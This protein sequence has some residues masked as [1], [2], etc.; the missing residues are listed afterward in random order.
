[1]STDLPVRDVVVCAGGTRYP[2][3]VDLP[4]HDPVVIAADSGLH[5]A[6]QLSLPV[7]HVVGDFDSV[8]PEALNQA[9]RDGA[10]VERH[11]VDK[12]HTDLALA[13]HLAMTWQPARVVVIGGDGG[14]FD[15]LMGVVTLLAAP[16]YRD[17]AIIG[18]LGAN[19][20]TV[21]HHD[22]ELYGENGDVV[23]LV[24]MHGPAY[25]VRTHGLRFALHGE[26]LPAGS[27]R[28]VSNE[29]ARSRAHVSLTRGVLLA[30]QPGE[31][32]FPSDNLE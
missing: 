30:I 25:E 26:T 13:L 20:I 24:P 14:R 27:T 2:S 17:V 6:H 12:D 19:R 29:F 15:H 11:P 9:Q 16:D 18:L 3:S 23:S 4:L 8:Q 21:I 22:A 28:G 10:M 32:D 7:H 1:M 5:L 31:L